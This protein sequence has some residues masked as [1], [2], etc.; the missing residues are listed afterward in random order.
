MSRTK[1]AWYVK[2]F[3]L[4]GY[5]LSRDREMHYVVKQAFTLERDSDRSIFV[6]YEPEEARVI[7]KQLLRAADE[8][9][10]LNIRFGTNEEVK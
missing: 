4:G 2:P 5:G 7:A 10:K 9:E 1:D 3:S 8:A 6:E